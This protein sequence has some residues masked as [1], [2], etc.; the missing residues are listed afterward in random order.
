MI[1]DIVLV[2]GA[3][4]SNWIPHLNLEFLICEAR[5]VLYNREVVEFHVYSIVVLNEPF[6][7]I[8]IQ[9]AK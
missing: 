4:G 8:N 9:I 5:S 7:V 2:I 1:V 3:K 6:V